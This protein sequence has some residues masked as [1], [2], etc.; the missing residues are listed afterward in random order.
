MLSFIIFILKSLSFNSD[1]NGNRDPPNNRISNSSNIPSLK[2]LFTNNLINKPT[3]N[4]IIIFCMVPQDKKLLKKANNF[5]Y[6][7]LIRKKY[8]AYCFLFSFKLQ[9]AKI[10]V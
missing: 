2:K 8:E 10:L 4:K 1:F 5:T 9:L 6:F 3:I 7:F